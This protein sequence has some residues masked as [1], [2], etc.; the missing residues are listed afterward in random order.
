MRQGPGKR[1]RGRN[2]RKQNVPLRHQTFDSNGPEVRIRGNAY[3]VSEKYQALA[4]DATTTGDRIAAENFL[5][6]AEHYYRII[7]ASTDP[8]PPVPPD[9]PAQPGQANH[10]G[11]NTAAETA[12]PE[13]ADAAPVA[14]PVAAG[15]V[16][17][18]S[19]QPEA[20]APARQPAPEPRPQDEPAAQPEDIEPIPVEPAPAA[21]RATARKGTARKRSTG[22]RRKAAP[23]P[24][25]ETQPAAVEDT[26]QILA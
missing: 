3:Q 25:T 11:P 24:E 9:Q 1:P 13:A 10:A 7:N 6:H 26:E 14:V 2:G 21:K 22:T 17:P 5:Q 12:R 4:R 20:P 23:D 16:A 19:E 18:A 15:V 8:R